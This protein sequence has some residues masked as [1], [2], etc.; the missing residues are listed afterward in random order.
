M[1]FIIMRQIVLESFESAVYYG[2]RNLL[3]NSICRYGS[4]CPYPSGSLWYPGSMND[5]LY[6]ICSDTQPTC[7]RNR[8]IFYLYSFSM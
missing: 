7:S 5:A 4:D 1:T 3:G 8:S 2:E 6:Q